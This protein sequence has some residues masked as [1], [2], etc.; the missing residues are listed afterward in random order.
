MTITIPI[1]SEF[2]GKGFKQAEKSSNT[3]EKGLKR[4]AITLG[5]ALSIRKIT[6]FG[7]A[8]SKAF[9]EEDKAVRA[10]SLNLQN[11]GLAYD[12]RPI[13]D[14]ITKL[15]F[16]TG[17]ADGELRPALN[18]LLTTVGSLSKAQEILNLGLDISAGT[19]K[20][21]TSVT[22]ALA[23]AYLGNNTSLGR[24]N[25]GI[26]KADL[27]A[28]SFAEITDQLT[29]KF[30]GQASAAAKTY[31]GQMDVLSAAAGDAQETIG[32]GLV[33]ALELLG[34]SEGL[35]KSV[36]AM[37]NLAR[38][39]SDAALATAYAVKSV[40]ESDSGFLDLPK[41]LWL[42]AWQ[43]FLDEVRIGASKARA[44]L[45]GMTPTQRLSPR[46]A[47]MESKAALKNWLRQQKAAEKLRK[48]E[49][50][51][52][53]AA[54]AARI[55]AERRRK[56]LEQLSKAGDILD[57]EKA[58][59]EAALKNESLSENEI[60]RLRL[61][62]A[63]LNENAD[64]ALMLAD[65]LQKSQDQLGKLRD[66]SMSF[67]PANPFQSW[68]DAID[69]LNRKIS[70]MGNVP[71]Q[72][73]AQGDAAR[74]LI[75]LGETTGNQGLFDQGLNMLN[76]WLGAGID[77]TTLAGLQTERDAQLAAMNEAKVQAMTPKVEVYVSGVGGLDDQAKRDVVEAVVEA[78]S[79]GYGTGWFRTTDV[80][81]I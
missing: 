77:E 49:E 31:A 71:Q 46:V 13:E 23:R 3:L 40:S 5:A 55:E 76:Q 66:L 29:Q 44:E 73:V 57:T 26:S 50:R 21:L 30:R 78:S 24:L 63:I 70:L 33:Q 1:I 80:Y 41:R 59:V 42:F 68:L 16:A 28:K 27:K 35:T 18:K 32:K 37:Q 51:T 75:N 62:K 36:T 65:E 47:E 10:L 4:L 12:V 79:R 72:S 38:F 64:R 81:A 45:L 7:K 14:Y 53:K 6:Q 56:I 58:S 39:A 34:G 2:Q 25:V 60:L 67:K 48:E 22:D 20:S 15:Q 52:A 8:A 69:E 54:K 61:K 11:L 74:A 9:I 19:G 43:P 17:V